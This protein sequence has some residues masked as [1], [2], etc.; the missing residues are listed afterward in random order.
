MKKTKGKKTLMTLAALCSSLFLLAAC[1]PGTD[2][3]GETEDTNAPSFGAPGRDDT[4]A[5]DAEPESAPAEPEDTAPQSDPG[6]LD[7]DMQ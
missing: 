1:E 4:T 7:Q 2:Q 5:P 6:G 3:T